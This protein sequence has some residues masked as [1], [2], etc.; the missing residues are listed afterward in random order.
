MDEQIANWWTEFVKQAPHIHALFHRQEEWDLLE[1]MQQHFSPI[2][3]HLMWEFGP[4][5]R[6]PGHRLVITPEARRE[7]RPLVREVLRRAPHIEGWE[8]YQY[9]LAEKD[10]AD[11]AATVKG[12]VG[13]DIEH[14]QVLVQAGDFN[15]VDLRFLGFPPEA[16][17]QHNN[18]VAFVAS[19]TLLGE[20]VLDRWI[21]VID[22]EPQPAGDERPFAIADLQAKVQQLIEQIQDTLPER[23]WHEIDIE[24]DVPW[25]TLEIDSE[26]C[27]DCI[28][29]EDLLV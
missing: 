15:R 9:R 1:W 27:E 28:R 18:S 3:P 29:Q 12:R 21:G 10:I 14:L 13:G 8:F 24:N 20:E 2:H 23:P 22:V 26:E 6:G 16:D 25:G 17:T 7:L 11:A 19:E 4:A 5:R